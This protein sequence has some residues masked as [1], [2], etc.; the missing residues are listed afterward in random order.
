[1]CQ[2]RNSV[3]LT[4]IV[5]PHLSFTGI[6]RLKPVGIDRCI[7]PLVRALN[8]GGVYTVASCCGHGRG[9]G[10]IALGDGRELIIC[11]N[12]ESARRIERVVLAELEE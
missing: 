5:P 9:F 12:Y 3:K 1:M 10:N 2:E 4:V 8:E 7:A 11:P 6:E